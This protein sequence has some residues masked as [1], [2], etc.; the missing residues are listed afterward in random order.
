MILNNETENQYLIKLT[1]VK[2]I[3]IN[4][5]IYKVVEIL[6]TLQFISLRL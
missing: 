1:I 6:N 5:V 3:F 4:N 2:L